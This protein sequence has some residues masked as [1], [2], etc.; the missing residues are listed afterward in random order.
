[1]KRYLLLI[2]AAVLANV[3]AMSQ[4]F[5][6]G[7]SFGGNGEDVVRA[8]AVDDAGNVYTTGYFT[9]NSDMDPTDDVSS[10]TSNGFFDIF[11][12]KVDTDGNLAWVRTFG[13]GFFDYGTG[14]EV[15]ESGN[16]YVCGIYQETV[17]FD[18]GPGEFE[19]TS[20]GAEDVFVIKLTENGDFVWARSMGGE[21]YEEPVS[22]GIDANANVYVAGYFQM[23]GD[24]DPGEGEV[25]LNSN[26]GQDAFIVKL[27]ANGNYL[28][29]GNMGGEELDLC[30]GMDVSP[31]G[32]VFITGS[33]SGT[34]DFDI[35]EE[36]AEYNSLGDFDGYVTKLD[37]L[38]NHIFTAT[39]GGTGS[40]I[41]W[42]VAL[43][44]Q[45]NVYSAGGF[46]GEF[47]TG[48]PEPIESGPGSENIFVTKVDAFGNIS[49]SACLTGAQFGNAYDLNTDPDGNVILAGYFADQIDFDPTEGEF[50]LTKEST[51]PFDAFVARLDPNGLLDYAA[52][53]GGS[54]FVEH[55][56][57]DTDEQ[58]NIY[59]SAGYQNTVDLD[60]SE[61]IEEASSLAFRDSYIIKLSSGNTTDLSE[62]NEES[63]KIYPNPATSHV[64]I[65]SQIRGLYMI[66]DVSGKV[67]DQGVINSPD[68]NIEKLREGIYF[69]YVQG[70]KT[71]KFVKH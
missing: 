25:I 24:Y 41:S 52:N 10:V 59:L 57:V 8:M 26:G 69:I 5:L 37:A 1:M 70:F 61:G 20:T 4:E 67:V 2:L 40:D 50:I 46:R 36:V 12:Q 29:A 19:L 35:S 45:G 42:D 31:S 23:P 14:I 62:N 56:G 55:H 53:F 16:V 54:N 34:A 22:V 71:Q 43:D 28:W 27:D 3:P 30:L 65:D 17:D 21:A 64:R 44:G 48:V 13:A 63:F 9:D 58:G 47:E 39:I 32:D 11:V 66:L 60:P 33:F 38:G 15:D 18:P 68:I 7:G 51:E 6:W 49:W